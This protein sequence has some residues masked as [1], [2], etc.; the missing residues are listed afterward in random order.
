V[1]STTTIYTAMKRHKTF[2]L[3]V[4]VAD[5]QVTSHTI[6]IRLQ[7]I[8]R[9]HGTTYCTL[10]MITHNN[11]LHGFQ[12]KCFSSDT[13]GRLQDK[14]NHLTTVNV[15]KMPQLTARI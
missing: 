3:Q 6:R 9:T 8:L 1:K 12:M 10:C 14:K 4:I 15:K 13:N 7:L 2:G 5:T 11:L